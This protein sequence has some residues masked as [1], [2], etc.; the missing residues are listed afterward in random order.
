MSPANEP[1]PALP[2]GEWRDTYQ[3]LHMRAQ[4]VGKTRLALSPMENHWWNVALYPSAHGLTTSPLTWQGRT[5]EV[6]LDLLDD[7]LVV[8]T[9]DGAVRSFRLGA[10]SVADFYRSYVRLLAE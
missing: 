10:G 1:W 3:A 8:R 5:F 6:E 9:T 7:A 2:L 4:I